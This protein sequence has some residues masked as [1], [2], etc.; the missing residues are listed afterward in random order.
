MSKGACNCIVI[1]NLLLLYMY[2]KKK[3]SCY[4]YKHNA[5]DSC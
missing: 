2:I 1:I 3:A 4:F 5:Y